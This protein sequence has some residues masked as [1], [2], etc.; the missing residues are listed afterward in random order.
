M[1]HAD[2][3]ALKEPHEVDICKYIDAATIE[4][5]NAKMFQESLVKVKKELIYERL[6]K[7]EVEQAL[8]NLKGRDARLADFQKLM[9]VREA[10]MSSLRKDHR[11]TVRS[12]YTERYNYGYLTGY[13]RKIRNICW[14]ILEYLLNEIS[15]LEA[16]QEDESHSSGHLSPNALVKPSSS[17]KGKEVAKGD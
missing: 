10:E 16:K 12:V 14:P 4:E 15:D 6:P 7:N 1:L 9:K 2:H 3:Q 13:A 8:S 11:E 17:F 5:I